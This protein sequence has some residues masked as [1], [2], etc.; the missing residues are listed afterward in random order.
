M[1]R[2]WDD[3]YLATT[4]AERSWTEETPEVSLR[5]IDAAAL[6]PDAAIIDI[7]GGSSR[8]VDE[9]LRR[10]YGDVS[11]L[12]VS[13]AALDEAR[14]RLGTP[15]VTWIEADILTWKSERVYRLWHDRAV[16]HFL[17]D[18]SERDTYVE[19]AMTAMAPGGHLIIGTFSLNGPESCS[20]R[21]V[22]QWD[23]SSLAAQFGR[24]FNLVDSFAI[25]HSTPWGSVQAFT[26]VHLQRTGL[27]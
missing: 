26:W 25:D 19:R 27:H 4:R 23:A 18:E 2:S 8:L 17:I 5:L 12:D 15:D 24:G 13:G 3:I 1:T 22:H 20:G 9:L 14:S 11:V 7:G 21:P 10:G 6:T 16:F